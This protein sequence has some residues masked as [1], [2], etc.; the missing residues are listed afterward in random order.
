MSTGGDADDSQLLPITSAAALELYYAAMN[1]APEEV[2]RKMDGILRRELL[3]ER[4]RCAGIA[5]GFQLAEG[6]VIAKAIR[7]G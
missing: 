4:E 7:E 5:E 3:A 6:K 2:G 1:T